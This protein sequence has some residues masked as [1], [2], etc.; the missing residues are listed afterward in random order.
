V[1]WSLA[2]RKLD[3]AIDTPAAF[4]ELFADRHH[5]FWLDSSLAQP[6]LARFS[7]LG[8]SSGPD[9]EIL[10]YRVDGNEVAI[11]AGRPSEATHVRGSIFEVLE[12]RLSERAIDA[13][14]ELPFDFDCGYVGY[15][16]YELKADC[17]SPNRHLSSLPDAT[18][19]FATRLLVVDHLKQETW[20]LALHRGASESSGAARL[21][22]DEAHARTGALAVAGD[23]RDHSHQNEPSNERGV[24]RSRPFDRL[25]PEPWLVRSRDT[26]IA[27]IERC[28]ERLRAGESYQLCLTNRLEM[29]FDGDP[30]AL[31]LR[32]RRLNPAPYAAYLQMGDTRVLCSSPERFL[33]IGRDREIESKPIKGTCG[34]SSDPAIDAALRAQLR[35]D[36]KNRAENVT[37]VDLVRNDLGRVCEPGSVTVPSLMAVES[38]A[39]VHQL[40]ST[41]RGRLASGVS[42]VGAVRVC[43]P[44]G[45]MTGAPKLRAMEILEEIEGRARGVYSGAIGWLGLSGAA[46]LNI[47]IRTLVVDRGR[48]QVGAGGAITVDSDPREEY[49]EMLL[50]ARAPLRAL[51]PSAPEALLSPG[52]I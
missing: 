38:Y 7:F 1:S 43:F 37:I 19:I 42:A 26:Y 31:Y 12:A 14:P 29:P 30:L 46:D 23:G 25:D 28:Q 18:L 41:V 20:L 36:P 22:L 48:L 32:Q 49:E 15:L 5:S 16:G 50:K 33:R 52:R 51:R 47:V 2:A 17:E 9:G 8:D 10:S 4:A 21:W 13:R 35:A 3:V 45:S 40:V 34:R 11:H 39:T 27:D 6:G 44:G 24:A